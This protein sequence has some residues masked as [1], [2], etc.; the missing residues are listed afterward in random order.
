MKTLGYS[1]LLCISYRSICDSQHSEKNHSSTGQDAYDCGNDSR[2]SVGFVS[3]AVD[4][5]IE[6]RR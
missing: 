6:R 3:P 5:R 1:Y 2:L 4:V